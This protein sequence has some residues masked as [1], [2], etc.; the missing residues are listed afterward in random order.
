MKRY[1]VALIC[2]CASLAGSKAWDL[3]LPN[4]KG[5]TICYLINSDSTTVNV[6]YK[7]E[8]PLDSDNIYDIDTLYVPETIVSGEKSYTVVGIIPQAFFVSKIKVLHLS[9]TIRDF[10]SFGNL[11][12]AL[13]LCCDSLTE[14]IVDVDNPWITAVDGVL[15]S[16]DLE[17]ILCF[18]MN[19]KGYYKISESTS[20]I[21]D[22]AF[23]RSSLDSIYIPN[24]I[25]NIM[26]YS[27]LGVKYIKSLRYPNSITRLESGVGVYGAQLEEFIFGSGL[28]YIGGVTFGGIE[29]VLKRIVCLAVRPPQT[30]VN[31]F[32]NIDNLTLFVPRKSI[33]LYRQ[34]QGWSLFNNIEPIEPPVVTGVNEAEIS[35]VTNADAASYS[36]TLY[37]DSVHTRRLVTLTF[38]DRG[39][40]QNMDFNPDVYT[41]AG[42]PAFDA[43]SALASMHSRVRQV[44]TDDSD[45][46][47]DAES[48]SF[49]SYLSFT[50]TGLRAG[51]EYFFVRRTYNV[52]NE[53]IDEEQGFF[54]TLSNQPTRLD[55]AQQSNS[56]TTKD[57]RGGQLII[58]AP[59][60]KQYTPSGVEVR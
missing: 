16:K 50:V 25:V 48:A 9:K 26:P 4:Q 59:S 15:F 56:Q 39:Y 1:L 18:P 41:I 6:T 14:I 46:A 11:L 58:T 57:L 28:E 45:D 60:G 30:T 47:D 42:S 19:R 35:W 22:G 31:Q 21:E 2:L 38:D 55:N 40:L 23:I 52:L 34:A 3:A 29:G 20:K 17:S 51:S 10:Y 7:G 37:L 12:F 54:E 49:N 43:G 5:D 24:S 36:L 27:F 8:Q 32:Y 13:G 44:P 33:G 53:V